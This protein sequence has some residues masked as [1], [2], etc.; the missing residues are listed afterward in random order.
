MRPNSADILKDLAPTGRLRVAIDLGNPVL[1]Q[2]GDRGA[3]KGLSVDFARE[4]ARRT[5]LPLDFVLYDAPAK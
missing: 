1:A 5:R 3:P 2:T 4:L